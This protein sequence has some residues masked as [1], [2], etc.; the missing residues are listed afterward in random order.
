MTKFNI[1]ILVTL[2]V[3][4]TNIEILFIVLTIPDGSYRVQLPFGTKFI[5]IEIVGACRLNYLDVSTSVMYLKGDIAKAQISIIDGEL[6]S[7]QK[8]KSKS[9]RKFCLSFTKCCGFDS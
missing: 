1:V 2:L 6:D 4:M 7:T 3:A 8:S 9:L 5:N